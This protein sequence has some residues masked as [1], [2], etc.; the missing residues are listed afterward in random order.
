MKTLTDRVGPDGNPA[1]SP[2]GLWIAYTGYDDRN[3]TSTLSSLYLMDATG[4]N[5]RLWAGHLPGSPGNAEWAA[6]GTGIYYSMEE[7]GEANAYFL[8]LAEPAQMKALVDVN[9]CSSS[10]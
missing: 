4:G 10:T 8:A 2:D 3:E 7:R 6:D 9:S 5:K 1:M